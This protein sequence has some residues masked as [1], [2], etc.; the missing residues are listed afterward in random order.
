[1]WSQITGIKDIRAKIVDYMAI[2]LDFSV[3]TQII[4]DIPS[5]LCGGAYDPEMPLAEDVRL[6]VDEPAHGICPIVQIRAKGGIEGAV[7]ILTEEDTIQAG[8]HP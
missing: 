6:Q 5:Y 7:D 1:V 8:I 2:S 4:L 3:V